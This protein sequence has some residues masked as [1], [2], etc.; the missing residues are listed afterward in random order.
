MKGIQF[1]GT[2]RSGSNLLR[3]ILNQSDEIDAPHPPHILKVFMPLLPYYNVFDKVKRFNMLLDDVI[4]WV[5]NNTVDWSKGPLL[6]EEVKGNCV[7]D[8]IYDIFFAVYKTHALKNN[9]SIWCCKSLVNVHYASE[10]TNINKDIH[11]IYLY[12][13]G[14]DVA[15]SFKKTIVGPKHV[16]F[17]AK[18]WREDQIAALK[19]KETINPSNFSSVCYEELIVDPENVIKK[20][21]DELSVT[22]N[23]NMLSYYTSIESKNAANSGDMWKNLRSPIL[24][25]NYKKYKVELTESEISIFEN[26]AQDILHRLGY[27][28]ENFRLL[29][30]LDVNHFFILDELM[31]SQ[32]LSTMS[33]KERK[34]K[35][36]QENFINL[37]KQR[38]AQNIVK[39]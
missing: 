29:E 15:V 26:V 37:L 19:F 2:Q 1:I 13:D 12:R 38:V 32:I 39:L 20:L 27:Q 9:K 22:F 31:K 4:F 21:C 24:K 35:N 5:N 34:V 33:E 36:I 25:N 28:T 23:K 10:I 3:V 30:N 16:Y 17:V 7:G 11:Y 8:T 6:L 18:Q 14:R